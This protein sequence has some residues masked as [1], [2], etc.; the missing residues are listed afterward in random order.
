[1]YE[2]INNPTKVVIFFIVMKKEKKL[3]TGDEYVDHNFP[4]VL[5]F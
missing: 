2:H 4:E 1:M 3:N 5:N